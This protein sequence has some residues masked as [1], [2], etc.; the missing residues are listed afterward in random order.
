MVS[1]LYLFT[2][3][4]LLLN[5]SNASAQVF[6]GTVLDEETGEPVPYTSI[7]L[8]NTTL[9]VSADHN[10][11][12]SLAIPDGN[13]EVVV[14][15]LGY[16][17]LVFTLRT[18][19]MGP[20]YLI[21]LK[22]DVRELP[23]IKVES[24]RDELWHRNLEI[25]KDHFLGTSDRARKCEILN[26]EVLILDSETKPG[27]LTA[28]AHDML[29]IINPRLGYEISYVLIEFKLD[30][31][32]GEV[33]FQGHPSYTNLSKYNSHLPGRIKRNREKA[34]KGSLHHFLK[35]VY[36][37]N[38]GREGYL[39]RQVK[40]MAN[41]ERPSDQE[42]A[43]AKEKIRLTS[44]HAEKNSLYRDYL[45]KESL[46][47]TIYEG[48]TS[49]ANT[50]E[51]ISRFNDGKVVLHFED[52]LEVTYTKQKVERAYPGIYPDDKPR[53]QI[54]ILRMNVPSTVINHQGT[55]YNPF[56]I[57][58]LGYMGWEK[59]GDMMPIDYIP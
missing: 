20:S 9:G 32:K 38:A 28:K 33:F 57:F 56:D 54:S 6:E 36:E 43:D 39:V 29:K 30:G 31:I 25:F 55:T 8:T 44:S 18:A 22:P 45:V 7:F 12:F 34:Y 24:K 51:F 52:Y 58:L 53:A 1:R 14:R 35:S 19:E 42:I 17:L 49:Y 41:P 26:P 37:G 59:M 21:K 50:G 3:I 16:N 23:D 46:P 15:M 2:T 13:Y 47:N 10:G 5:L 4:I 11:N 40:K 27:V 48:E